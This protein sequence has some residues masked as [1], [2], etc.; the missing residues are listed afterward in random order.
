M[1]FLFTDLVRSTE[2]TESLGPEGA[3]QLRRTHFDLLRDGVAGFDVREVKNLGDGL[4]IAAA[5]AGVAVRAAVSVQQAMARHNRTA[6]VPLSVRIGLHAGLDGK[7]ISHL[8]FD[9]TPIRTACFTVIGLVDDSR[10][11]RSNLG[12]PGH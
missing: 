10:H 7:V 8:P 1:T 4:M 12:R 6:E 3:D 5:K 2:L 11:A 9:L